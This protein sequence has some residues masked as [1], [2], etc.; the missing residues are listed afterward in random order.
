MTFHEGCIADMCIALIDGWM[1]DPLSVQ[2]Q[3]GS[4]VIEAKSSWSPTP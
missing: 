2:R 4:L 1:S 3:V